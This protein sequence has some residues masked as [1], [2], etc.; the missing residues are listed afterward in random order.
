[1]ILFVNPNTLKPKDPKEG[2]VTADNN[3]VC[4]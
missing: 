1:M 3:F 4:L 2:L